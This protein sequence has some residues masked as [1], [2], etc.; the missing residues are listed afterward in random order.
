MNNIELSTIV[1]V[2]LISVIA[3]LVIEPSRHEFEFGNGPAI[4]I[5]IVSGLIVLWKIFVWLVH[6]AQ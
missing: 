1:I 3:S 6:A 2:F 4:L 5:A